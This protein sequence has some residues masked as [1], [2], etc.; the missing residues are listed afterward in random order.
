[1]SL[2][3]IPHLT[4]IRA[5]DANETAD[6]WR[7]ALRL[8]SPVALIFT[9]Q[10]LPVLDRSGAHGSLEQGAYVLADSAERPDIVLLATGSEVSLALMA[11]ETLATF[12][13]QARVVS[14]PS[15]ELFEQQSESYQESVLGPHGTPRLSVEAGTTIGWERYTG[16]NGRSVGIDTFGASGPG[17]KVMAHYGFTKEHVVAEALRLLDRSEEAGE[18]DSD[19]VGGQTAGRESKGGEGHS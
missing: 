13:V 19:Y 2:R 7:V 15:W 16:S 14:F 3:L 5:A 9:R 4:V 8:S 10:D 6:A 11:R 12:D 1:M 17:S 18:L